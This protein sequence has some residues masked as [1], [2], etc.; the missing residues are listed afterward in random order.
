MSFNYKEMIK[1]AKMMQKR[2]QEVKEEL[3][4][5][6][7]EAS[8]GGGAVKIKVNGEQ[9]V[10]EIKIDMDMTSDSDIEMLQDMVMVATNDAIS[11]SKEVAGEKLKT[12]TGGMDI[13]GL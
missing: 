7:F 4:S 1:Q 3:K 6:T 9:E 11:Q 5:M 12:V 8:S 10:L 2:M 13:P